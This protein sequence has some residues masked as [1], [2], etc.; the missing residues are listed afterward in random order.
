MSSRPDYYEILRV[1][2]G[3]SADE[4]RASYRVIVQTLSSNPGAARDYASLTLINQAFRTLGDPS[5]RADYDRQRQAAV[6]AAPVR[7]AE[8]VAVDVASASGHVAATCP[9]C[10]TAIGASEGDSPDATCPSCGAPL[11]PAQHHARR[12][13]SRREMERLPLHLRASYRRALQPDVVGKGISQDVSLTGMRLVTT[14]QLEVGE[15]LS[16]DC[17]FCTAVGV[18][19]HART[20]DDGEGLWESGIQFLTLHVKHSRGGLLSTVA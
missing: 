12:P 1:A 20:S 4:I 16:I 7:P 5:H 11:Y 10:Q 14:S 2:P 18:V 15:R 3:A 17:E 13:E 19:R 9:F 8:P 6:A